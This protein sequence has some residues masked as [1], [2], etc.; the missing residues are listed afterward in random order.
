MDDLDERLR[1]LFDTPPPVS[2][3]EIVDRPPARLS[4]RQTIRHKTTIAAGLCAV[5]A[6][7]TIAIVAASSSNRHLTV[8]VTPSTASSTKPQA[9]VQV[10]IV[11]DQTRV[12]AGD[13]IHGE[14]LLINRTGRTLTVPCSGFGWISVGLTNAQVAFQE[15]SPADGCALGTKVPTGV[16]RFAITVSTDYQLCTR[17]SLPTRVL[18]SCT[19]DPAAPIPPLPA[20]TYVTKAFVVGLPPGAAAPSPIQVTLLPPQPAPSAG[21]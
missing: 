15:I 19:S 1:R 18:P 16:N 7:A 13:P 11:L 5:A 10:R 17:G 6:A 12:R 9:A 3:D 14:A 21:G 2:L 4:R 20:G 8:S